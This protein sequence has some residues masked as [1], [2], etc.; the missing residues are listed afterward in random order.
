[1]GTHPLL[2]GEKGVEL[3]DA[4]LDVVRGAGFRAECSRYF[5]GYRL[6]YSV[7][8]WFRGW[9]LVFRV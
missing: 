6:G 9:G 5:G 3:Q 1:M 8:V 4:L 2:L 7:D